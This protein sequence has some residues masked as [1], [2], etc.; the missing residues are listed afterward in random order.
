MEPSWLGAMSL[1]SA[2]IEDIAAASNVARA[3]ALR[4]ICS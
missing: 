4:E 1:N 3:V 2:S